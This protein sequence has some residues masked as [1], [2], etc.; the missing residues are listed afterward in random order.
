MAGPGIAEMKAFVAI[1]EQRSFGKAAVRLGVSASTLSD[2]LTKLEERLSIRLLE[3]T[4]RSVAVT[5]AGEHLLT[6]LR[7]ALEA[8]DAALESINDFR[9]KPR[10]QLRITVA[11]P[12]ADLILAPVVA[13]F[14]THYPEIK[15][16]ISVDDALT[17]IVSG[18]FDAGIRPGKR[19][20]R[21]MIA[22]RVT[23]EMQY[24]VIASPAYLKGCGRLN[25][26]HDLLSHNCIRFRLPD[27]V[28]YPWR[29]AQNGK[30]FEVAVE[31]TLIVNDLPLA[32]RAVRDGL[33]LLQLRA[34]SY[35]DAFIAKGELQTVLDDW[36]LPRT[37]GYFLYY[38]SRR[39]IRAALR[40]FIDFLSKTSKVKSSI[41]MP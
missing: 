28:L 22:V 3:R 2:T 11:K 10:G 12:A 21:D 5:E 14:L 36:A 4:T 9:D 34:P 35:A 1:A 41:G 15:L 27:G 6:H 40:A 7:P 37:D 26:P 16:E 8:Y 38:S 30:S 31:G 32:L 33:G 24:V 18:R 20:E 29:F 23:D 25:T 39:H 17:D 13:R 19:L